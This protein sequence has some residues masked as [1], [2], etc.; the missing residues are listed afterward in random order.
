MGSSPEEKELYI[1]DDGSGT[2]SLYKR[3]LEGL[4]ISYNKIEQIKIITLDAYV[5][6]NDI[7]HID[8]LKIDIEGHE[9]AVI[10]GAEAMLKRKAID[11]IQF[12]YGVAGLTPGHFLWI[13]MIC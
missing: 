6:E 4:D 9:L 12:E 2:N 7:S 11:Y 13:C 8:F 5:L 3:R 10:H 1:N